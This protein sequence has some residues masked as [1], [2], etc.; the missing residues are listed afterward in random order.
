MTFVYSLHFR[1][2]VLNSFCHS[3]FSFLQILFHK[4]R[5][6]KLINIAICFYYI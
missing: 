4:N 3:L 2:D 5:S 1:S 6:Y